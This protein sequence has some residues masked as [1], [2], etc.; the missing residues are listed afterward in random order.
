MPQVY[1][2]HAASYS[3]FIAE[4]L[5]LVGVPACAYDVDGLLLAANPELIALLGIDPAGRQ[6]AE[7][8]ARH[9]RATSVSAMQASVQGSLRWDSCLTCADGRYLSVQASSKPLPV[10]TGV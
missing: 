1:M 4:A 5:A 3:E 8:F 6:A 2:T 9:V 10:S 7:L